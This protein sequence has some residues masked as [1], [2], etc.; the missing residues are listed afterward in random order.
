M[1]PAGAKK[2]AEVIRQFG[3]GKVI[4]YRP[5]STF[6]WAVAEWPN[7]AEKWEYRVKP[8]PKRAAKKVL[9]LCQWGLVRSVAI[10]RIL[11]DDFGSDAIAA[12]IEK[13]TAE[14][15][16]LLD[17]WADIV[18]VAAENLSQSPNFNLLNKDKLHILFLGE[19]IWQNPRHK[20]LIEK[21][22]FQLR[23]LSELFQ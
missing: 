4:E 7:F 14:T 23:N 19:D 17:A 22:R 18:I 10:R 8:E 9:V 2:H 1:T 12:G 5:D 6:E 3:E 21:S 15:L 11:I 16:S 20:D 13:N